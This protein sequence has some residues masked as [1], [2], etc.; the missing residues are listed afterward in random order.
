MTRVRDSRPIKGKRLFSA[1]KRPDLFWFPSSLSFNG[2]CGFSLVVKESD[3][4][5]EY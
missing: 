5:A 2:H 3:H 1:S 4:E